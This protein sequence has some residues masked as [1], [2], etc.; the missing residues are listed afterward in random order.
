MIKH[1]ICSALWIPAAARD[2][3]IIR[4]VAKSLLPHRSQSEI[5][6]LVKTASF[7]VV[8]SGRFLG[9]FLRVK[10]VRNTTLYQQWLRCSFMDG[11]MDGRK[12]VK[13]SAINTIFN[14]RYK[15]PL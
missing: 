9:V 4:M 14:T 6:L 8:F 7:L 10:M 15:H 3:L 5:V 11:W 13:T 12:E 1:Q 2:S